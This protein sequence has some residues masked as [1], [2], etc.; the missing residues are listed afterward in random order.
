MARFAPKLPFASAGKHPPLTISERDWKRIE[1]VYGCQLSIPFREDVRKVTEEFLDCALLMNAAPPARQAA[2]RIEL[3]KNAAREFENVVLRRPAN[4]SHEADFY[5]RSLILPYVNLP[6]QRGRDGL[7]TLALVMLEIRRA[8]NR[9]I[10]DYEK[11]IAGIGSAGAANKGAAWDFWIRSLTELMKRED[12]PTAAR[13]DTDKQ[14]HQSPFVL[15][16]CELQKCL[17]DEFRQ[18]MHSTGALA[19]AIQSARRTSGPKKSQK[20]SE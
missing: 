16:V 15:F 17:P 18:S 7:Q 11:I 13:K 3:I 9:A 8:C 1:R 14:R 20:I 2:E 5:A 10:A 6:S 19:K 4:I 12:L